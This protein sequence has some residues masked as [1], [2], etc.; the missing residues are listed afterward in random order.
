MSPPAPIIATLKN[1]LER[2]KADTA[3]IQHC[4]SVVQ[5]LELFRQMGPEL[6]SDFF[7]LIEHAVC[8]PLHAERL[9]GRDTERL[10]DCEPQLRCEGGVTEGSTPLRCR[11]L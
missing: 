3:G 9:T 5:R 6:D 11:Q 4:F 8:C 10:R 2:S 1:A 7:Q